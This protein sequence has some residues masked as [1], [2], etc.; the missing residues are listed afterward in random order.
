MHLFVNW[1]TISPTGIL[2]NKVLWFK[3][4]LKRGTI[5]GAFRNTYLNVTLLS[6]WLSMAYNEAMQQFISIWHSNMALTNY[7]TVI[8]S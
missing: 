5:E 6:Q 4:K 8:T 7:I 1:F 3:T 2:S